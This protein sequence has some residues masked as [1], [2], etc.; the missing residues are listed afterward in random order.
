MAKKAHTQHLAVW[1]F[2]L[3][4]LCAL[5]GAGVLVFNVGKDIGA[6]E[7]RLVQLERRTSDLAVAD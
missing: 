7:E 4:A 2:V 6:Y 1:T 3:A 5:G